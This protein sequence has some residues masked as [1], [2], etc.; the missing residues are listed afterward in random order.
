M[1]VTNNDNVGPLFVQRS[2]NSQRRAKN[3]E[4][5][6]NGSRGSG[7]GGGGGGSKGSG[8]GGG[9]GGSRGN[10]SRGG[11]KENSRDLRELLKDKRIDSAGSPSRS[12]SANY[13]R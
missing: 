1:L 5:G 2:R 8:G 13:A 3:N 6:G 4:G 9:G 12:K 10:N 11:S 7:G